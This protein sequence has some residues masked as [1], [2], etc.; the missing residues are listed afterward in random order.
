MNVMLR[1][2]IVL[3]VLTGS[4]NAQDSVLKE[5]IPLLPKNAKLTFSEWKTDPNQ[6]WIK[7]SSKALIP[8]AERCNDGTSQ[9]N[10]VIS[11]DFY[12]T[13]K[14][15]GKAN[16][17]AEKTYVADT[18]KSIKSYMEASIE[19]EKRSHEYLT[20][21]KL[22]EEAIGDGKAFFYDRKAACTGSAV[23]FRYVTYVAYIPVK[24][25]FIHV[26]LNYYGAMEKVKAYASEIL[27][28]IKNYEGYDF[29]R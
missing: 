27:N 8:E 3:L 25:G 28:N 10:M 23:N 15:I 2:L 18:Y 7:G 11:Y 19:N 21:G 29:F 13:Q 22:T 24:T 5:L 14:E 4:V 9:N 6:I 20:I 1:L 26:E 12:N 17:Q 16:M